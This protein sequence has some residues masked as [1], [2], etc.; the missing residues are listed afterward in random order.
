[1]SWD[2]KSIKK[3]RKSLGLSQ[4]R[5]AEMLGI[6]RRYVVYLEAGKYKPSKL[7]EKA[8]DCIKKLKEKEKG[9]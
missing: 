8:L 5:F 2:A 3:F 4:E 9:Q 7:L 1:M 6:T